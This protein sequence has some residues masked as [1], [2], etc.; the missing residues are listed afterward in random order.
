LL[1]K[2]TLEESSLTTHSLINMAGGNKI[3]THIQISKPY[4]TRLARLTGETMQ[5]GGRGEMAKP[6]CV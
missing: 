3:N 4:T 5:L 2:R 6:W 1:Q